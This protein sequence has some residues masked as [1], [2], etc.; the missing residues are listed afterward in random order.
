MVLS[1]QHVHTSLVQ[2]RPRVAVIQSA[3]GPILEGVVFLLDSVDFKVLQYA[4]YELIARVLVFVLLFGFL[5][6]IYVASTD[7]QDRKCC[8]SLSPVLT[9][10]GPY[11]SVSKAS[12]K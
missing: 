9:V 6:R 4:F 5:L 11:R 1:L 10:T 3:D 12:I 8:S 2:L 7:F